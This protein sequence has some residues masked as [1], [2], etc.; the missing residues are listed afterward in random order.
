VSELTARCQEL[1]ARERTLKELEDRVLEITKDPAEVLDINAGGKIFSVQRGTLCLVKDSLLAALFSG[2]WDE[3]QQRDSQGRTFLE[4]DPY[5][6]G[7]IVP[8]AH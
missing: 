1:A 2:N 5:I 8:E 4:I 3:G 6:F 7:K